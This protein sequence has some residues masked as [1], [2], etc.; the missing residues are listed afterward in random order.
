MPQPS[1]EIVAAGFALLFCAAAVGKAAGW[2]GWM[3]LARRASGERLAPVTA[4]LVPFVEISVAVL[5]IARAAL[6]LALA[7]VVLAVFAAVVAL[8]RDL[9]RAP[10]SCFGPL[11]RSELG[12]RLAARNAVL[13]ALAA[14]AA[15]GGAGTQVR[16]S[17]LFFA[18][19]L[20]TPIAVAVALHRAIS[21]RR[22]GPARGSHQAID[23]LDG[24]AV[25]L[26]AVPGCP[27]CERLVDQL[28]AL[29]ARVQ[30]EI[31][32]GPGSEDDRTE[33]ARRLEGRARLDLLDLYER[34]QIHTTPFA[35][36]LDSVARVVSAGPVLSPE[37]LVEIASAALGESDPAE[38]RST[39]R[40]VLVAFAQG[41]ALLAVPGV[42]AA[43]LRRTGRTVVSGWTQVVS[44]PA[45][46]SDTQPD[47][48]HD[49]RNRSRTSHCNKFADRLDRGVYANGRFM[50]KDEQGKPIGGYTAASGL[51]DYRPNGW[52]KAHAS[53]CKQVETTYED[54]RGHCPCDGKA[55]YKE[56]FCKAECPKGLRCFGIQCVTDYRRVC[57]EAMV[58]VC[59]SVPKIT[60]S[61]LRWQPPRKAKAAC[62]SIADAYDDAVLEHELKHAADI[63]RTVD[64]VNSE[65][66]NQR[67][68]GCG[69]NAT[70]ARA[71][72]NAE[73]QKIVD[74]AKQRLWSLDHERTAE[75]HATDSGTTLD[76]RACP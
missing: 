36:A 75:L 11:L 48:T 49:K 1:F 52:Q 26:F 58:D 23:G 34:W 21:R 13:A 31:A 39:R 64:D 4:G 29:S 59:V 43:A 25:I 38:T 6:G 76:C 67:A 54:W 55:Y 56:S 65:F 14:A 73:I 28:P 9:R 61:V 5:C 20:V 46:R 37:R 41:L 33:L 16:S 72:L 10:C 42:A 44:G 71:A 17:S 40:E 63:N 24:P 2:A 18:V 30:L 50:G 74:R 68:V 53:V 35:V 32:V 51:E 8:R 7:A 19:V 45:G 15:A 70:A 62:H 22:V 57:I 69:P 60:I 12:P 3:E 27:A 66:T 47:I